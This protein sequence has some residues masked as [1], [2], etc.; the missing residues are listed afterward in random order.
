VRVSRGQVLTFN[1][2]VGDF[3]GNKREKNTYS[4]VYSPKPWPRCTPSLK[5]K[6]V[7]ISCI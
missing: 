4:Q 3:L 5:E 2:S 1:I 6:N 7:D